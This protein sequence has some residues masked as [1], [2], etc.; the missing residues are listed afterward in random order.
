[1]FS[2]TSREIIRYLGIPVRF[3]LLMA[4]APLLLAAALAV[5]PP[6]NEVKEFFE[7]AK[8]YICGECE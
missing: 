8:D 5:D 6:V 3:A 4:V 7:E 1:M 2:K